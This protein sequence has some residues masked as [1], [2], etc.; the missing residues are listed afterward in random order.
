MMFESELIIKTIK[1]CFNINQV[2]KKL[3]I[4][5]NRETYSYIRDIIKEFNVNIDHFCVDYRKKCSTKYSVEDIFK[6][7]STYTKSHLK[8]R[9]FSFGLKEKRCEKCG[10]TE[11]NGE[12]IPLEVHHINGINNDNRVENL[13]ILCPNCHKQ[14]DNLGGKNI[15]ISIRKIKKENGVCKFCG[16]EI[17]NGKGMYCSN[18]CRLKGN[19][20]KIPN[21]EELVDLFRKYKTFTRISKIFNVSDKAVIKWFKRCGLPSH[22]KEIKELINMGGIV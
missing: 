22:S 9:I 11:W 17:K 4:P 8:E 16:K 2:C 3:G 6:E 15:K 18:E 19:D 14:T 5:S 7:N 21:K 10:L 20:K 1:E 12:E 13:Q